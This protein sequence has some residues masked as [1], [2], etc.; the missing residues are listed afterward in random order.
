VAANLKPSGSFGKVQH[1]TGGP[2]Q[3]RRQSAAQ[4]SE[5]EL[6]FMKQTS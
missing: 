1:K 6:S 3:A 2:Q 5:P 4:A